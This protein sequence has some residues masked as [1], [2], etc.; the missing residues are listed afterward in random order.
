MKIKKLLLLI[1]TGV[2]STSALCSNYQQFSY[3]YQGGFLPQPPN[4]NPNKV[5]CPPKEISLEE[6][7]A[8]DLLTQMA[9]LQRHMTNMR[10]TNI[11]LKQEKSHC[12]MKIDQL[13][14][15]LNTLSKQK[16]NLNQSLTITQQQ[17]QKSLTKIAE[18]T[19]RLEYSQQQN[20]Q[21]D[22]D[23]NQI[24]QQ[25]SETQQHLL[26]SQQEINKLNLNISQLNQQQSK[27]V[28]LNQVIEIQ[29]EENQ[30]LTQD[31]QNTLEQF[32]NSQ[33]KT[34]LSNNKIIALN[35]KN[36][37]IHN[38]AKILQQK[39]TQLTQQV[40]VL[41]PQTHKLL[42]KIQR[43]ENNKQQQ[44][45]KLTKNQQVLKEKEATLMAHQATLEIKEQ[46]INQSNRQIE[47][48]STTLAEE[49]E[50]H[51]AMLR[52]LQ[53]LQD[54]SQLTIEQQ[55]QDLVKIQAQ[56]DEK[57]T[58]IQ[59]LMGVNEKEKAGIEQWQTKV[60]E[61][62]SQMVA[63]EEAK[64]EGEILLK[65]T[66]TENAMQLKSKDKKLGI[67]E[68]KLTENQEFLTKEKDNSTLLNQ[69]LTEK[70]ALLKQQTS[71][72]SEL[73]KQNAQQLDKA[74]QNKQQVITK[75][76]TQLAQ[77]KTA[78]N[79]QL[80][81]ATQKES[82]CLNNLKQ[83]ETKLTPLQ[84]LPAQVT[85][86][87]NQY[88]QLL[89][90]TTDTDQDG[91]MDNKDQ[92]P[93]TP[94]AHKV[95][96]QG[97]ELDDDQDGVINLEDLC[98]HSIKETKVDK[99]G[100][101]L[102]EVINLAGVNFVT[103]SD[104]LLIE[105]QGILTTVAETLKHHQQ[106][107]LEVAGHTDSTGDANYNLNLSQRRA[108]QVRLYLISQGI[109]ENRLSAQGYG[110]KLPIIDNTSAENRAMNRRVELRRLK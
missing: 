1:I 55:K 61:L 104:K 26:T 102:N 14:L 40:K 44:L 105:S 89:Q 88:Q 32:K 21:K 106:L 82:Q 48:L 103:N 70:M 110:E 4:S 30:Q 10:A 43:L 98:P 52:D 41:F 63:L 109:N 91:I 97:C 83:C 65:T 35:H 59:D 45:Q 53:D 23:L 3:P 86:L 8:S 100:C 95:N 99:T 107:Q 49:K 79:Q 78:F 54:K 72:I 9:L 50:R 29:K 24:Q 87:K 101:N 13:V 80:Q 96:K 56:A 15:E 11:Q 5:Y 93:T 19:E 94:I 39:V 64:E 58:Q 66:N 2:I 76:T 74:K 67:L 33:D 42:K 6:G 62:T 46:T 68:S 92:C 81:S 90:A 7:R 37:E 36:I 77:Q 20:K 22:Q 84:V 16:S 71:K 34:N 25:Y 75:L 12:E 73:K 51:I 17:T 60:D 47:E 27:L 69:R 85:Q 57:E 31:L 18:L 38:K 28:Q 108:E